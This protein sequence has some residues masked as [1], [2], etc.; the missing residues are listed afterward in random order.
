[1]C[2]WFLVDFARVGGVGKGFDYWLDVRYICWGKFY[3]WGKIVRAGKFGRIFV[4]VRVNVCWFNS[5]KDHILVRLH[6]L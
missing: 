1:M 3:N 4:F 2:N 5:V 6:R